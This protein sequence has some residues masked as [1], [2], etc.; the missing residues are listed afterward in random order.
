ME[1]N[2]FFRKR[3]K[4]FRSL[5]KI[6][7]K[8]RKSLRKRKKRLE[9]EGGRGVVELKRQ[10]VNVCESQ[11]ESV[12]LLLFCCLLLLLCLGVCSSICRTKTATYRDGLLRG[13]ALF[14]PHF[15][16]FNPSIDS[17]AL[18]THGRRESDSDGQR[19][20]IENGLA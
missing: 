3:S 13:H 6:I 16:L 11:R 5:K 19:E 7:Y 17:Y 1:Q 8:N 20:Q 14:F 9:T 10:R 18:R 12:A 4:D 15:F 2:V